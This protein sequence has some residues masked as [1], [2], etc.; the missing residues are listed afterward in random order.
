[1]ISLTY[2]PTYMAQRT[3]LRLL[4][5][6][7]PGTHPRPAS[8]HQPLKNKKYVP[9]LLAL[10]TDASARVAPRPAGHGIAKQTQ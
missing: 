5:T 9:T 7:L 4:L 6:R 3:T 2:L 10:N 1:M 8:Q